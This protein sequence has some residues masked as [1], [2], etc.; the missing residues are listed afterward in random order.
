MLV[1]E[2]TSQGGPKM[3]ERKKGEWRKE[4]GFYCL[5]DHWETLPESLRL[6]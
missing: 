3:K 5:E 2:A 4:G 6:Q 1:M